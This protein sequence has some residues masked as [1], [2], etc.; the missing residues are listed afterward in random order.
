MT[1]S[2]R[3]EASAPIMLGGDLRLRW[4]G[5]CQKFLFRSGFGK[6]LDQYFVLSAQDQLSL[7]P[8]PVGSEFWLQARVS[9]CS[10]AAQDC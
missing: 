3:C 6:Q 1:I 5:S 2:V 7:R 4:C 10:L 9:L 8:G